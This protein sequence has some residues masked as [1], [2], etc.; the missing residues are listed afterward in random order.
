[1]QETHMRPLIFGEV[2]FDCFPDDTVVLGGAPFNV[3]WHIQAFGLNPMMIT[4]IGN[5][6]AG[7][8]IQQAMADW[9]MDCAGLQIDHSHPT[10]SVKVTFKDGEPDYN[11]VDQVAY[12]YIDASL[13][14]ALQGEYLLYHGSLAL[15]HTDS[16]NSLQ[17]LKNI[18]A[19]TLF[20]DINLRSPWW[21]QKSV[22]KLIEGADW[23][24]LNEQELIELYASDISQHDQQLAKVLQQLSEQLVLTGGESGAI[25]ISAVDGKQHSI[26]P[27]AKAFVVDTVGA[28]DSFCSVLLAGR[29]LNWPLDVCLSRAQ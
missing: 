15:R 18:H 27:Q 11:I 20:V 2:L 5:D 9:G 17:Q 13:L 25:A 22:L 24:K 12:D 26:S 7:K 23:L 29:I 21:N 8:K 3:A 19:N 6:E 1:M 14:P 4:R 10:G 28:G 16:A